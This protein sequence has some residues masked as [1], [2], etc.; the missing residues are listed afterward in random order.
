MVDNRTFFSSKG[1]IQQAPLYLYP[2]EERKKSSFGN[3]MLFE[4]QAKYGKEK[5][6]NINEKLIEQLNKA[7]KKIPSPEEILYYVYAVLYSNIYREK[8]SEFLK[9]DFPRIPFTKK[10]DLFKVLAVFGK[11]LKE[12]HLLEHKYLDYPSVKYPITKGND[13]IEKLFYNKK[14]KKIFINEV[15]CFNNISE[16]MWNYQIGGY[17]VLEKY[18]KDRKGKQIEES[19]HYCRIASAIKKTIEI[20]KDIDKIFKKAE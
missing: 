6:A 7:Y 2:T 5:R 18:L 3:M 1:I 4:P 9:I 16:E 14:E 8:Y 12:L 20:Q 10:Y 11:E 19:G 13:K 15:Q 17:Q